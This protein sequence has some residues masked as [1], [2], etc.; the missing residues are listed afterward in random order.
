[1][2]DLGG[3]VSGKGCGIETSEGVVN[4]EKEGIPQILEEGVESLW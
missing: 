3:R 2:V 1:M 4:R